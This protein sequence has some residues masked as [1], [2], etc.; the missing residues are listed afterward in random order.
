M[1]KIWKNSNLTKWHCKWKLV[2]ESA[3]NS[4]S[5]ILLWHTSHMGVVSLCRSLF[6]VSHNYVLLGKLLT[7]SLDKEFEN[8]RQGSAGKCF[9]TVQNIKEK[10]NISNLS[11]LLSNNV[12]TDSFSIE[13]GH[14]DCSFFI[15]RKFGWNIWECI[16]STVFSSGRHKDDVRVYSQ[17]HH[18]K[19]LIIIGREVL[20]WNNVLPPKVWTI[21]RWYV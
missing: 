4:L 12:N 3:I 2:K 13:C 14:F 20:K 17:V 6:R 7:Y 9:I 10:V 15:G 18:T 21:S 5:H 19:W 8:L 11:P 16:R 1:R